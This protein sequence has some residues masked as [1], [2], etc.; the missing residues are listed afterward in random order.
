MTPELAAQIASAIGGPGLVIFLYLYFRDQRPKAPENNA[1]AEMLAE[2]REI[3][4]HLADIKS[5]Q[6][7]L[8]D[9]GKR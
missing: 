3:K 4:E 2:L 5:D 6:K 8:L 1:A 7:V 9:R